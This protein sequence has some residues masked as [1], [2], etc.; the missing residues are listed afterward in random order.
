MPALLGC[1]SPEGKAVSAGLL[2][3]L[4]SLTSSALTSHPSLPPLC[5]HDDSCVIWCSSSIP[6]EAKV[7]FIYSHWRF[8][9]QTGLCCLWKQMFM[10]LWFSVLFLER[11]LGFIC[12]KKKG[13]SLQKAASFNWRF[14]PLPYYYSLYFPLQVFNCITKLYSIN[15]TCLSYP[16]RQLNIANL[17]GKRWYASHLL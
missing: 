17:T 1:P 16:V 11:W 6:W 5:Q 3:A 13:G 7:A 4:Y 9:G 12:F 10:W 8:C 15:K 2:S 14:L